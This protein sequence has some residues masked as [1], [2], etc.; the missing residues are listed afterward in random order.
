MKKTIFITNI[1]R[2]VFIFLILIFVFIK[3]D[4]LIS[5][6]LV[7]SF[8]VLTLCYIM[9]NTCNLFNKERMAKIFHKLFII[10]FLLFGACFLVAWSYALLRDKIYFPLIFTIPFWIFEIYI[11][12][13]SILEIQPN[14]KKVEKKTK[15]DFKIVVSFFLVI[16]VLLSGIL[17]LVIGIRDT[18]LT[19]KR[20]KNYLT[21]T[22]Y[23]KDYEIFNSSKQEEQTYRL[24][25]VYEVD[26]QEYTLKTDYGSGSIP[27]KN[28][29]RE[30]KYNPNNPN[31][32]VF[33]GT[34][35]NSG[36]IYFGA[37]F[38]L[39]SMVFVLIFLTSLGVFDKVRINIIGLYIGFVFL[40]IG[41]GIIAFQLGEVSS[42]MEVIKRMKLWTLIPLMFIIVGIFQII[43]CLFFE[44]VGSKKN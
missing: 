14:M 33:T 34:N 12:R 6:L 19:N 42:L 21:T 31:E 29:E 37:F 20:T 16:S 40:I 35:R 22:G 15:F 13:K 38:V 10:I 43:K 26:G 28:S 5:R 1:I 41:I 24:I 39:G 9:E 4:L 3:N 17:C 23:F 32:A 18:Y 2:A 27:S 44:K 36:L 30:I 7:A 25:Y 8:L 11:F